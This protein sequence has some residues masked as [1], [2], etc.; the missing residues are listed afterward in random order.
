MAGKKMGRDWQKK[1]SIKDPKIDTG[2]KKSVRKK[3]GPNWHKKPLVSKRQEEIRKAHE[4][5]SKKR[6][7]TKDNPSAFGWKV[8]PPKKTKKKVV[9]P[10]TNGK[11][12]EEEF[13]DKRPG[14][15]DISVKKKV[16]VKSTPVEFGSIRMKK[17]MIPRKRAGGGVMTQKVKKYNIGGIV[18]HDS[19]KSTKV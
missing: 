4:E 15:K 7:T 17:K 1:K 2:F 8:K 6:K 12:I 5:V 14:L 11:S 3:M 9:I 19:T 16:K 10:K 18:I 13:G